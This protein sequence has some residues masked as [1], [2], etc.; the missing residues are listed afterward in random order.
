MKNLT[1]V[2]KL[3]R[4][5]VNATGK[6][7]HKHKGW[8]ARGKAMQYR[9]LLALFVSSFALA[10]SRDLSERYH[11]SIPA[12]PV[13]AALNQ[14]AKQSR[15][16]LVFSSEM[17]S[18]LTSSP[19]NGEYSVEQ[20]L[21]LVLHNTSLSGRVTDRGVIIIQ[22]PDASN[23]NG[24][25]I[26]IMNTRKKLLASTIAFF[27]GAGQVSGQ[28][29]S[30]QDESGGYIMEEIFV[31]ASKRSVSLQDTAMSVSVLGTD[32]IDKRNLVG[33]GDY[34]NSLPGI[35]VLD[36]GP[37]F[38]SVVVRGLT[39]QPQGG[40]VQSTAITGV[41]F[42]ETPLS[43]LGLWGGSADIKL[44]DMER[45]EV[46]RGPQGTLYGAGAMGGVVRNIPAAPNLDGLEGMLQLDGSNTAEEGGNNY[47]VNGMI[48]IPLLDN[49]LALRAVAY[50]ID[51]SGYYNNI[52]AD[53]PVTQQ[54][55]SD[56][57]A[58]A[59]NQDDI[60]NNQ[61]TGA[62]LA[63]L[64]SPTDELSIT[65]SYLKQDTEQ[66]GWGQADLDLDDPWSQRRLRIREQGG[67]PL[68]FGD[69]TQDEG[70]DDDVEVTNLTLE[71]DLG[72]A[73]ILSSS[74]W[75]DETAV[76]GRDVNSFFIDGAPGF[77]FAQWQTYDNS[78]FSQEI[79]LVSQLDGPWQ[80]TVGLYYEDNDNSRETHSIYGGEDLDANFRAPGEAFLGINRTLRNTK[81]EAIFGEFYYN[82]TDQVTLTF[83]ARI[84]E[85]ER[86]DDAEFFDALG[87]TDGV[88]FEADD[89]DSSYK[90]GVEYSP[91]DDTLL[92]A[93]WSEGF[94]LGFGIPE[95]GQQTKDF[96][97]VDND[98]FYDG[99]NVSTGARTIDNDFVENFELGSKLS[100]LNN[101]LTLNAA[102][103][104]MDWDGIP[105]IQLFNA[106][107][108]TTV[109]VGKAQ[110]R[111]IELD[112]IYAVNESLQLN[113]STSYIE[114]E[115]KEA[116]T[117][118]IDVPSG[119]RLPGSPRFNASAG[120]EYQFQFGGHEAYL[121]SDYTYVGGFY[122]NPQETGTEAG[123]YGTLNVKTGVA[124]DQ[125]ELAV[126]IDN[127][128]NEDDLTWVD[129][130][131]GLGNRGN[132]LQPRTLGFN[133]GY[134]F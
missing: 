12:Q 96:C 72:W 31:T 109:N 70:F 49:S 92:Y 22:A 98:G 16:Q 37:S 46:L 68:Y 101:Q 73:S 45:V 5:I 103:F 43:G 69:I 86:A 106:F 85:Y 23:H 76:Q 95:A 78:I 93:M 41:Y 10:D 82:L 134:R 123:D 84:F 35:S 129:G 14:L 27:I 56:Y 29:G 50:H 13:P 120:V 80:Y 7:Q 114:A 19:V 131:P 126:Y 130:E 42:G 57:G 102:V 1:G 30:G 119:S 110:S 71:Y 75:A 47:A 79:R 59:V 81:Q 133:L 2:L 117:S 122:N 124:I 24:E 61:T 125:L 112:S 9:L 25:G 88:A 89:Q 39:I 54:G 32:T 26:E 74:S 40:D 100:L 55:V 18:Q 77:P 66:E 128:T 60:G 15:Y 67:A 111:G 58:V 127:L 99:S 90:V 63:A 51:N 33:M 118:F 52:A 34:L 44:I 20:A 97:D 8:R 3:C 11:F 62:R 48:N 6:K 94:R 116:V 28:E 38:T 83:G 105:L 36:Q 113:F 65:L 132:R 104:Q 4:L 53:D 108:G 21:A 121:R 64:W 91:N 87:N 17:L 115:T 107:C